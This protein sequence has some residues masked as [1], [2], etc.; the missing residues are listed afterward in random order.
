MWKWLRDRRFNGYKF[1]REHPVGKYFLD[2]FCEEARLS[3]EL[4]G[5]QHGY[6]A[7]QS[8]DA[9]RTRFLETLGIKE[10]RFWNSRLRRESQAVRDTIFNTLQERAPHPLPAYTRPGMVGVGADKSQKDARPHPSP[11]PRGEGAAFHIPSRF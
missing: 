1:R 9:E 3:I 5:F 11:L 7:Q 6:P 8:Y 4:D 10:L 2:F